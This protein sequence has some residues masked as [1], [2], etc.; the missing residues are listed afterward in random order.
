MNRNHEYYVTSGNSSK[1]IGLL[2]VIIS[3][4]F[5]MLGYDGKKTKV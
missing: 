2:C 1:L 5:F 4:I 3:F